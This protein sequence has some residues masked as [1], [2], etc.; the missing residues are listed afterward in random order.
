MSSALPVKR[1]LRLVRSESTSEVLRLGIQACR[2]GKWRQGFSWLSRLRVDEK[3]LG[4]SAGLY[5][6]YLGQAMVR[7]EGRKRDGLD[8]CRQ[9][10]EID[11]FQPENHLNL[12][13]VLLIIGN[14]R[15]ALRTL[16]DGLQID[17]LHR[18]SLELM[19]RIG[20]RRRPPIPFLSRSNS[21]NVWLGKL[22]WRMKLSEE[23]ARQRYEEEQRDKEIGLL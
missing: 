1:R 17:P 10:V 12:A 7:C 14:R 18:A 3:S 23:E 5:F 19:E 15:A 6:G 4:R 20:Q 11:P 16:R 22:T 8:L 13:T 9:A 21:L 2:K